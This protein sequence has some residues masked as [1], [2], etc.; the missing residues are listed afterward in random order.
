MQFAL[1]YF[2]ENSITLDG[3]IQNINNNLQ[4]NGI[5]I[6]SCLD[7]NKLF[8]SLKDRQSIEGE[9]N[10]NI[11]WRISKRYQADE[12]PTTSN[13]LG[14]GIDVYMKSINRTH[15]EYLV[16]FNYLREKIIP[17]SLSFR[18]YT[19]RYRY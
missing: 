3:L 1:H 6:G 17:T 11:I 14:F 13:C 19:T 4:V 18:T 10:G 7:G 15:R 2:T 9:H 8:N 5:L 12:F 16:N